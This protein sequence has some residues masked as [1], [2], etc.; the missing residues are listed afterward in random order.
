MSQLI[1]IKEVRS[2]DLEDKEEIFSRCS[3]RLC[4]CE[5]HH[6][7]QDRKIWSNVIPKKVKLLA[8]GRWP[9]QYLF[10]QVVLFNSKEKNKG[11]LGHRKLC[12]SLPLTHL[13][14]YATTKAIDLGQ[15]IET[16]EISTIFLFC[17]SPMIRCAFQNPS[18]MPLSNKGDGS[19]CFVRMWQERSSFFN[20]K[21][22]M[23][24]LSREGP[25]VQQIRYSVI[26]AVGLSVGS[27]PLFTS[28]SPSL[29]LP[30]NTKIIHQ[31]LTI[32][33][34]ISLL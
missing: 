29:R 7:V 25:S 12:L 4:L 26:D 32:T 27:S 11:L 19:R 6:Q 3:V 16:L 8:S 18:F 31:P 30:G 9:Y 10:F 33:S 13:R 22:R 21:A 5:V 1:L 34:L 20:W 23:T 28:P 24:M 2:T 14:G 17:R 15:G